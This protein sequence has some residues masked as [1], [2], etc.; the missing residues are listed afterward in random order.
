MIDREK[1][2]PGPLTAAG[3]SG[4][5]DYATFSSTGELVGAFVKRAEA[6]FHA[7]ARNW[8]DVQERRGFYAAPW[9]RGWLVRRDGLVVDHEYQQVH[10][11]LLSAMEW[12][13]SHDAELT[14]QEKGGA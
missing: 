13:V 4:Y 5:Y 14:R 2:A 9:R 1:L 6:D 11:D 3:A 12:A 8:L 7:L 10:R